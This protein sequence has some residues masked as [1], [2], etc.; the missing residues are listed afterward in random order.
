M[1]QDANGVTVNGNFSG[2]NATQT[3]TEQ[4][5]YTIT[6][7]AGRNSVS[8]VT[9]NLVGKIYVVQIWDDGVLVRDFIP[10]RV[11]NVGYMYDRV[12]GRLFGNA[13]TGAFGYGNDLKYPIPTE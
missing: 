6:V 1:T 7:F 8:S 10:V 9:A 12:S 4:S 13:G 2:Y 5:G 11:G 3:V